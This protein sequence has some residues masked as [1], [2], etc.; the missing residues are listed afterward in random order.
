MQSS[1]ADRQRLDDIE[2]QNDSIKEL[3]LEELSCDSSVVIKSKQSK[4]K[5]DGEY[6]FHNYLCTFYQIT[7]HCKRSF[8]DLFKRSLSA[9]YLTKC[10]LAAGYFNPGE[11][12]ENDLKFVASLMLRHLQSCSCNA[13]EISEMEKEGESKEIGGAVYPSISLTNHSCHPNVARHN[14]GTKCVLTATRF[15]GKGKC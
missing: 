9:V 8:G 15:I 6:I 4:W 3:E 13:Y 10:L 7:N 5:W 12:S 14:I 2:N 11:P 1:L